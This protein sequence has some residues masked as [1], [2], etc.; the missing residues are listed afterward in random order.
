MSKKYFYSYSYRLTLFIRS[1]EIRY[2]DTS[3]NPKTNQRYYR[4]EKS[5]KLDKII[6]LYNEVKHEI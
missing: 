5:N 1:F 2:I 4:F 3:I 6:E